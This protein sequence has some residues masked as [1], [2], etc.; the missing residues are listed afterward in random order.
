VID[1]F[2]I[3]NW[4]SNNPDKAAKLPSHLQKLRNIKETDNPV[5]MIAKLKE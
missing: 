4:F 2:E 3:V 5:I 1:A